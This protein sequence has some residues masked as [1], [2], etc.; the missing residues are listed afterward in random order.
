LSRQSFFRSS[1]LRFP[2]TPLRKLG[3]F[4]GFLSSTRP[5]LDGNLLAAPSFGEP[6]S[7]PFSFPRQ[8]TVP[9]FFFVFSD[10]FFLNISF[11]IR[12]L[13]ILSPRGCRLCLRLTSRFLFFFFYFTPGRNRVFFFFFRRVGP[14]ALISL[15]VTP[16]EPSSVSLSQLILES[17]RSVLARSPSVFPLFFCELLVDIWSVLECGFRLVFL[18]FP[19]LPGLIAGQIA[20]TPLTFPPL[21]SLLTPFAHSGLVAPPPPKLTI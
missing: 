1:P 3:F 14:L 16:S 6:S 8:G 9:K 19:L 18:P 17:F 11:W 4:F 21:S 12:L 7:A 10:R 20:F 15:S 5:E 13:T 2:L